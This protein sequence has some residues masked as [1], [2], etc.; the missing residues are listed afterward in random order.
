MKD[1]EKESWLAPGRW[2]DEVGRSWSCSACISDGLLGQERKSGF[3]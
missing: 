3:F 2:K 1:L